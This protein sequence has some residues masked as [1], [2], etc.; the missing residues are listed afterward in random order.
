MSIWAVIPAA[1]VGTRMG[2]EIPKQYL[3]IAGKTI[4][5]HTLERLLAHPRI[6]GAMVA[7]DAN[8]T[9]WP[10]CVSAVLAARRS[11]GLVG[12]RVQHCQGGAT[13]AAS[14]ANALQALDRQAHW[15]V[16]HDA[17][18]PCLHPMD[19]EAVVDAALDDEVG[20]LLALPMRDT[21]K[22]ADGERTRETLDR[23]RLWC[24]QTPQVFRAELLARAL[25]QAPYTTDD[26][27]AVE[28]LGFTARLVPGR[29]SNLKITTPDDLA[30]ARFWLQQL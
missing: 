27:Q 18:R 1:G 14:V 5:Q 8:D 12:K 10:A 21:V 17:A 24:A 19:L 26:A 2:A 16:V 28:A 29:V 6:D 30:L 20:A 15:V 9:F 11:L 25:A 13:R 3:E 4:L 22:L 23:T 7:I